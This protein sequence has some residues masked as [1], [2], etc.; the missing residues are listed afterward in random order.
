LTAPP[1]S[2]P[3][4]TRVDAY[5]QLKGLSYHETTVTT[6]GTFGGGSTS[7]ST[8]YMQLANGTRVYYPEDVLPVVAEDSPPAKAA[9]ASQS[10]RET[11]HYLTLGA[12]A[13]VAAG[14][15]LAVLPI[16]TAKDG[17][18]EGTPILIGLGVGLFG[19][20]GLG[21]AAHFVGNSAQ[22]EAATTY[23]TYDTGLLQK[24]NLCAK[25]NG[26]ADCR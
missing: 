9:E 8:D 21:I 10:K 11:A 19:G 16:A 15:V 6:Y 2:A 26:L 17:N 25:D 20:A 7:H 22:D 13:A 18:V 3:V 14:I 4:Q 24:L 23:E 12:V 1:A 5:N